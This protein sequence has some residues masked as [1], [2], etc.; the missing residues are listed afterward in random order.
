MSCHVPFDPKHRAWLVECSRDEHQRLAK[1]GFL[2]R[3]HLQ[4]FASTDRAAAKALRPFFD[5]AAEAEM[6]AFEAKVAKS[7]ATDKGLFPYQRAGVEWI[8]Q[9]DFTLL[10]DEQGTGKTC[11]SITTWNCLPGK[12]ALVICPASLKLNWLR[13][14]ETWSTKRQLR[15]VI[16]SGNDTIHP[17]ASVVIC[18]YD[19]AGKGPILRQLT[20]SNWD[21]VILDEAH[22]LKNP[23]AERTRA[24]LG[25]R[26]QQHGSILKAV[27]PGGKIVALSGTPVPNR[28]IELYPL[29]CGPGGLD[30]DMKTYG[31]EFC[32]GF[33]DTKLQTW[34]LRGA[35]NLDELNELLRSKVMI[36]RLKRDVLT[37]L[38]DKIYQVIPIAK[39]SHSGANAALADL[40]RYKVED[41]VGGKDR[42]A[43]QDISKLRKE[44]A[45]A[46]LPFSLDYMTDLLEEL[47]QEKLV[48]FAYHTEILEAIHHRLRTE[49]VGFVAIDGSVGVA[50]RQDAVDKFQTDPETRVFVGQIQ[51]AGVGLTLTAASRVLF[52]EAS[53]VCGENEQA[54]DRCHRIG[55]K[56]SVLAQ[57]IVFEE[58]LDA[59]IL[60]AS[61][62]KQKA[63]DR[64][65]A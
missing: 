59:D 24:V 43:F 64:I 12:R 18:N 13:E 36:R 63:I 16:H 61:L 51:A 26:G 37:Q 22:Y 4:A 1:M 30:M 38:P 5:A 52:I 8:L 46:K 2:W 17:A 21:L 65:L 9:R 10:G 60:K 56:D 62:T 44:I 11:M 35:T 47:G 54:V 23:D 3:P 20:R 42:V 31:A 49:K 14:F 53:W 34:N 58:T 57:F 39:S 7:Y 41:I 15:Q 25:R 48:V 33:Y 40:K 45:V 6:Q 27:A 19:L 55:Q 50:A 29:L 28:P 32:G